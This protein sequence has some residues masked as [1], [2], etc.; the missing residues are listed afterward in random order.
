[1]YDRQYTNLNKKNDLN[2]WYFPP[3]TNY[4]INN[5]K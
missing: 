5:I 2:F 1:M 4:Q 3:D